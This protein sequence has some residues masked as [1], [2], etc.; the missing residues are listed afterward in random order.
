MGVVEPTGM[1]ELVSDGEA[2]EEDEADEG[3]EVGPNRPRE[4]EKV[5]GGTGM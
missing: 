1:V 5:E 3:E 4:P 2:A